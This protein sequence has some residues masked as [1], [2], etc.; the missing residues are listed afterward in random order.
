MLDWPYRSSTPKLTSHTHLV[1]LSNDIHTHNHHPGMTSFSYPL[2]QS[3]IA[4]IT[5]P[6][7]L[8]QAYGLFQVRALRQFEIFLSVSIHVT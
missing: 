3:Y 8:S 2:A 1:H 5:E 6:S 4:D 7:K